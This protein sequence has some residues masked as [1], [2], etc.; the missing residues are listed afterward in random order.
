M[1]YSQV[2]ITWKKE[3]LWC[4][5]VVNSWFCV[6]HSRS[7]AWF[8]WQLCRPL[9][10]SKPRWLLC[11]LPGHWLW[12]PKQGSWHCQG[13]GQTLNVN[14]PCKDT[15]NVS[16][17][18]RSKYFSVFTATLLN[19]TQITSGCSCYALPEKGFCFFS[20]AGNFLTVHYCFPF[21]N[22]LLY[23]LGPT[24]VVLWWADHQ[25][26][27]NSAGIFGGC[28]D[29]SGLLPAFPQQA[30]WQKNNSLSYILLWAE[31]WTSISF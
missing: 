28:T 9:P 30:D 16:R 20:P 10:W 7:P 1:S 2:P 24:W 19:N 15:L 23:R 12:Q 26:Q 8:Q 29:G 31:H 21:G 13:T 3:Y 27:G 6:G 14:S 18:E 5:E 17:A 25:L 4:S 22:L 11:Q